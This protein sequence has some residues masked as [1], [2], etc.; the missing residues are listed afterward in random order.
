MNGWTE[1][2]WKDSRKWTINGQMDKHDRPHEIMKQDDEHLFNKKTVTVKIA[3]CE[4][5]EEY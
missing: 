5:P 3:H 4:A 2:G 1:L